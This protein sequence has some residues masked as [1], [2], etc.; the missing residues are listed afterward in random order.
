MEK[1]VRL[2]VAGVSGFVLLVLFFGSWVV[3]QPGNAGVLFNSITGTLR[4][5]GQG[6]TLK[7][8]FVTTVKS[9]PVSLRTYTMVRRIGEGS[10]NQD[11][12]IDLPTLEG[13]HIRQD[14]SITYNTST[15]KA[16]EC[17]PRVQGRGHRGHRVNFHSAHHH[18]RYPKRRWQTIAIG[19]D[20]LQARR[21]A[22]RHSRGARQRARQNG[23]FSRQGE[24]RGQPFALC[25]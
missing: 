7:I 13:Q 8:P 2:V 18:H 25:H 1:N 10:S 4:T 23:V 14:V 9:Y 5:E 15:T 22:R 6:I 3:I 11:D 17:L 12:S 19:I 24:S 20:Q 16:A 21:A